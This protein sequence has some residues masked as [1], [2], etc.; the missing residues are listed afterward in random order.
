MIGALL[1]MGLSGAALAESTDSYQSHLDQA[2]FFARKRWY[3]D[4]AAEIAAAIATP[5]G[6][7]SYEA[8]A[9][10]AQIAWENG[11][12]PLARTM[13]AAAVP[14]APDPDTAALASALSD[15]LAYD[16][17]LV[18]IEAPYP[19]MR[20]RLQLDVEGPVLDPEW[21]ALINRV[22]LRAREQT[23]LPAT[24][25]LPAGS[26]RVNG[27]PV[28]VP[29]GGEVTVALPMAALGARGL[30]ALQVTRL[31]LSAGVGVW[32]G[33]RTHNLLPPA[34]A[35]VSL[36]QPIGP[37][38]VGFVG[39]ADLAAFSTANHQTRLG[40]AAL[41]AGLRVGAEV[42]LG[43]PLAL[44]PSLGLRYAQIPGLALACDEVDATWVCGFDGPASGPAHHLYTAGRAVVPSA[45][46]LLEYREAGRTTALGTGVKIAVDEAFGRLP[47]S[48]EATADGGGTYTWTAVDSAWSATGL[49]M[50]A[51]FA[52]TF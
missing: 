20:S 23:P 52:I 46:I 3:A 1:A 49:S 13:A 48:G 41:A 27:Q 42:Y 4:A 32:L 16:F 36:T 38:L 10:G 25:G 18:H 6:S 15:S 39:E 30:A 22:A 47:A 24:F 45:E 2:R 19:G 8:H 29:G 44:R 14:L 12:I 43:G 28:V 21:K 9:L 37:L 7:R 50:M 35:Q 17:G 34:R 33:A 51:N 5:E 26:Y 11:D 31:E 40:E